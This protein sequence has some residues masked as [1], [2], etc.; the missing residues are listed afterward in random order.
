MKTFTLIFAFL[1]V[2]VTASANS[3]TSSYSSPFNYGESFI[4]VEGGV[5]F[6]VYPNGEFDFYYNPQFASSPLGN[7][8]HPNSNISYNAGYNYDP[9]VQYDD[10]GAVIQIENVPVYYDYY[11]RIVQ[12]GNIF[13]NYNS[14]GQLVRL[15]NMHIR[16]NRFNQP[17]RYIGYINA[18]NPRYV[19]RPWHRYY[20]RPHQSYRV[21][22]YEP[23]RAYYEPSRLSYVQYNNYYQT[24]NVVVSKNNFYRPGQSVDSYNNGRRTTTQRQVKPQLRSSENVTRTNSSEIANS[25]PSVRGRNS[26]V[27]E[28]EVSSERGRIQSRNSNVE[29]NRETANIEKHE[30]A[31]RA[32]SVG[33]SSTSA[34]GTVSPQRSSH[35][36]EN[37]AATTPPQDN[38]VRATR[39]S[40][41]RRAQ[42][43]VQSRQNTVRTRTPERR[44][45]VQATRTDT[46]TSRVQSRSSSP[47][48]Q[49]IKSS[50]RSSA[51]VRSNSRGR[52]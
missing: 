12:A 27:S 36:I 21:V 29:R 45:N 11:G 38:T 42:P 14:R 49:E 24:N 28:A 47:R 26:S 13:I 30:A 48:S 41:E 40:V 43:A 7:I 51:E 32:Q 9:Y 37:R 10:F 1:F 16:Y 19:H 6:S 46:G 17:I 23:Y 20:V 31:V 5:E 52:D 22:Y 15:G 50:T 8:P 25:T 3:E 4:F 34:R 35:V 33:S 44:S 2:G 18:Y 39:P